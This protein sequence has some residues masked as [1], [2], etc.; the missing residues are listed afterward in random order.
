MRMDGLG[1]CFFLELDPGGEMVMIGVR[2]D[3]LYC[4]TG[5]YCEGL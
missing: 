4:T 1:G 2:V 5:L 3:I